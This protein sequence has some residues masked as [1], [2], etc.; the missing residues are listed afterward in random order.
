VPYEM[1]IEWMICLLVGRHVV[2][3][4]VLSCG[5]RYLFALWGEQ[6]Y[7]NFKNQ[8]RKLEELKSIK[9]LGWVR[10]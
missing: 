4:G 9:G 8:E 6:N 10:F 2:A 7:R 1:L 3:L 5:R